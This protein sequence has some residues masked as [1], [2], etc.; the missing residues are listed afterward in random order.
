MSAY[1]CESCGH[2]GPLSEA[3]RCEEHAVHMGQ[4]F[5]G[6]VARALGA[7][8]QA[9]RAQLAQPPVLKLD[10]A[11]YAMWM[12][13]KLAALTAERDAARAR[14]V[15]LEIMLGLRRPGVAEHVVRPDAGT[16]EMAEKKQ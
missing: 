15:E 8:L 1:R 4:T 11:R 16:V 12:R 7:R 6:M 14:A 10:A 13:R 9:T 3:C 5:A 2:D